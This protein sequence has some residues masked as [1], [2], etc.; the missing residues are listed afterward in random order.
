LGPQRAHAA[1]QWL[2]DL[3][4]RVIK[5]D[6]W[7]LEYVVNAWAARERVCRSP[8]KHAVISCLALAGYMN[9]L[10]AVADLRGH[11]ELGHLHAAKDDWTDARIM[12]SSAH[13]D[14]FVTDDK[15]LSA[16]ASQL[17]RWGHFRPEV[18]PLHDALPL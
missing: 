16:R 2:L 12:A 6:D 4:S 10:A 1:G 15:K 8:Q 7:F 14:I 17:K 11:H 18:K 5:T 9:M 3:P 13:T